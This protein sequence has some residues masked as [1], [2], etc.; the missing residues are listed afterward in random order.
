MYGL[1]RQSQGRCCRYT[2]DPLY[3]LVDA[4]GREQIQQS[5]FQFT[6]QGG[7]YRDYPFV[8]TAQLGDLD[9]LCNYTECYEYDPVGNFQRGL[10]PA[11]QLQRNQPDRTWKIQQSPEPDPLAYQR[12]AGTGTLSLHGSVTQMPHLP[13]M[14]WDFMDRLAASTRQ[15][16]H[17]GMPETT[18][19]VYDAS[20]QR[21]RKVTERQHGSR[22]NERL[23]IGGF[24]V[25]REY[26]GNG[27]EIALAR[28]TLH[29]IDDKQRIALI[30]T[31]T[32]DRE[33]S[34]LSLEPVQRYQLANH[35]GSASLE[36]DEAASIISYRMKNTRLMAARCIRPVAAHPK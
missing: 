16:V 29:I 8:G 34:F 1:S 15:V 32:I 5:V 7:D 23:Y 4:T 10:V 13:V 17:C 21:A 18:F 33:N 27:A 19:Y 30:D 20:G 11:L 35:L 24:E 25:F 3:R 9:A 2:Y 14:E 12:P 26:E 31:L 22:K 36:L 6:P 28:E